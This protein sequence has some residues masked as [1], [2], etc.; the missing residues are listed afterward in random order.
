MSGPRASVFGAGGYIGSHLVGHLKGMGY[1]VQA[2]GRDDNW[3]GRSLGHVFYCAGLTADF[4]TRPFDTMEAHAG[5]AAHILRDAEFDSFLY[6]SSTRIY[7]GAATTDEDTPIAVDPGDPDRLY[8]VSKLAGEAICHASGRKNV[9]VAR[10]SNVVGGDT[11]SDNFLPSLLRD[12]M[13]T[14]HVHFRTA[15]ESEKDYVWIGD[16]VAAL[17]A[18][19]LRGSERCYNIASGRNIAN[20]TIG[21]ALRAAT[22]CGVS[23]EPGAPTFRF[24]PIAT[25]RLDALYRCSADVL[26][27]IFTPAAASGA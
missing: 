11:A 9:R 18:I 16:A 10:L 17:E 24:P 19:A 21:D 23:Y 8:D 26:T 12:A 3:R 4:R 5:L 2:I 1:R 6:L 7:R 15:P 20:W 27:E 25:K 14:G 22:G 13:T